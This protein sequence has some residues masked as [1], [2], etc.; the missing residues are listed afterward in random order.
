MAYP[1]EV[2]RLGRRSWAEVFQAMREFT[3]SRTPETVDELWLVEHDPVFTQGLAGRPE[4][5]LAPAGI[6]IVQADRGG[7]VTYHGPG[8][9]VMYP[10]LDLERRRLGIRCLV[11]LLEQAVIDV[12][13]AHGVQGRRR[14]GMPGVYVNNDKI[15]SIG[16]K[17]RRGCCYH[18]LA[19][20]IAM[21]LSPFAM[22]NPCGYA[23]LQMTQLSA[24]VRNIDLDQ[25]GVE[26]VSALCRL[27]DYHPNWSEFLRNAN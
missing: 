8:Q 24:W 5:L 1:L 9:L 12:L 17:V 19:F 18:G 22:I 20:N 25:A 27:L 10:L 23:G 2:Q 11:D 3:D 13:A 14:E 4:H 6:P 7:Q 16:L 21:D 15:A 26:M